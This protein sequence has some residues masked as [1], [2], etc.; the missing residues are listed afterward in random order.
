MKALTSTSHLVR[1]TTASA[2]SILCSF[3][4]IDKTGTGPASYSFAT[5]A[6]VNLNMTTATTTTL[7]AGASSTETNVLGVTVSNTH[8]T[9][10]NLVTIETTDGTN[11]VTE[12]K[13]TL[14]VGER[15][16]MDEAGQWTYY[17]A[18]GTIKTTTILTTQNGSASTVSAGYAADTYLSGSAISMPS[19]G[20]IVNS[21][22]RMIFDM[23]KTA[24][25]TAT[26]IVTVRFGTAGTTADA[27]ILTFTFTA[28]TAAVDTGTFT[29]DLHFRTVGSG[30]AAVAVGSIKLNHHLAAT[31]LSALG[32]SGYGQITT[33][34]SGF[35]STPAGS[36]LGVSFNGGTSFSGTNTLVESFYR[37]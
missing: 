18:D 3:A 25:G 27:A 1:V 9:V 29:L 12:W 4:A 34:S 26:A 33:V 6:P 35:N 30:T 15:V 16:I 10:S 8:A 21:R 7:I 36:I 19:G 23:V 37:T 13:G 20:P 14:S 2:G 32:A 24:A 11:P 28:G 22:Y 31:G 5:R 17:A